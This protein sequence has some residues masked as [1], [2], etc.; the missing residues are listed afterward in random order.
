MQA[1]IRRIP[2]D[3][4]QSP[5]IKENLAKSLAGYK[6]ELAIDYPLS[7]LPPK[8]YFILHD[9]RLHDGKHY[10]QI[11]TLILSQQFVLILEI[12]N[13]AGVLFFDPVFNQLIRLK[14][15]QKEVFP[16]PLIQVQRHEIQFKKWLF[17]HKIP[18]LPLDSLVVISNHSARIETPPGNHKIKLKVIRHDFLF[19]RMTQLEEL[20]KQDRIDIILLKKVIR[21]LQK[22]DTPLDQSILERY[23]MTNDDLLRGVYCKKCACVSMVRIF[24][25]WECSIC[26]HNSKEAH[27][28]S[29]IDYYFLID[30]KINNHEMRDFLAI[31]SRHVSKQLLRSLNLTS[32]GSN[33]GRVYLLNDLL[34]HP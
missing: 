34:H 12:K 6:G 21:L 24:G 27:I 31:E 1:L 11:D 3:H 15:D 14:G 16:D 20:Y 22:K 28:S 23:R 30:K 19:T 9:V 29:L 8:K 32:Q 25:K 26:G 7:F 13:I 5:R 18:H 4:H 17:N 10:F 2:S 33:K